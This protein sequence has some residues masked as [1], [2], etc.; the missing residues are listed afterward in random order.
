[1]PKHRITSARFTRYKAFENF[2]IA[3]QDFNVLVGPNNAG[4]STVISAFRILAE[5]LR[6]ARARSP[7]PIDVHGFTGWGY[8]LNISD[9]PI[10]SENIFFDYDDSAPAQVTFRLSNGN[11]L[12]LHFPEQG[13][14]YLV[15]E[16]TGRI[17][18][19]PSQFKT[20]YD[21][22]IGFVPILGPVDP[23]EPVYAKEAARLALLTSGASR[24]FRNIWYHYREGF[25]EFRDLVRSTWPGM[26]IEP[27]ELTSD[28]RNLAM[29]C[30]EERRPREICW[31]GYGFQVWCQMLTHIAK[32]KAASLLVMD[33]PDIYLHSDLQRQPVALLQELGPDILIATHSTE[34]IAECEPSSLLNVSKKHA[35]AQR[36]KDVSQL[37]R[38]FSALGSNLN[39]TLTQLAKT[40]RAVFVEGLDFQ[41][42]GVFARLLGHQRVA[43]R[44]D[45]AVVQ[46]QGFNPK[47]AVDLAAGIDA[48]IGSRVGRAVVL[49][50]DYRSDA[51]IAEVTTD[52]SR[53]GFIVHIHGRKELEN[54][55]LEPTVIGRAVDARLTERA[56]RL[57]EPKKDI[58]DVVDIMGQAMNDIR[59]DVFAQLQAREFDF[60]RRKS[61]PLD[62]A[63]I[64]ADISK[65]FELAWTQL[66]GRVA[67][68][69]GKEVLAKVNSALQSAAGVSV[70]D[71]Q[72]AAQFRLTE[73]HPDIRSMVEE[74]SAFGASTTKD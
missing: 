67:M 50:R 12:R 34:I 19:T 30:P 25:E 72:I 40:K 27:P 73:V 46:I 11:H 60:L 14:C 55:L 71:M 20:D 31:A 9:L 10:A 6:R 39:P 21:V 18:R 37:K 43:N 15:P 13:A 42:F 52:L 53:N 59:H 4:K 64:T 56:R 33:E 5:G 38:V 17:P 16:S 2:Q 1:M 24:N 45:F 57:G 23:K 29:Y 61:S 26:D 63:T 36:V 7:E 49:D 51:E 32:A 69:P 54:Y 28:R 68:V 48:T 62:Q 58:P 22:E 44:A 65:R 47:R 70:S 35:S 41:V 66:L 8:R 74:L 3:L